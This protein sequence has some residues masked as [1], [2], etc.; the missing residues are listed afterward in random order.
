MLKP[1]LAELMPLPAGAI[2]I[3]QA[4]P[5]HIRDHAGRILLHRGTLLTLE[6]F[7]WLRQ[8]HGADGLYAGPDWPAPQPATPPTPAT[9][10]EL[11]AALQ[12][13]SRGRGRV[14]RHAR[15]PWQAEISVCLEF[16]CEGTFYRR[17]LHVATHDVSL[18]GFSFTCHQ[19]VHAG[20]VVYARFDQLPNR[21]VLK[22]VVRNCAHLE[23]RTHRV[24]VEFVKLRPHEQ[25]PA[26]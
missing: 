7:T 25:I 21:P 16:H 17:A 14:R 26:W 1:S 6:R 23:R 15:H 11:L 12:R 10:E 8:H 18:G 24:G 22:G 4:L 9:P 3:G 5:G 2:R 19:Y 13:Q 20:T